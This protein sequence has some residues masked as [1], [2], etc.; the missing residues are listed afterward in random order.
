[1][2]S[3]VAGFPP[4]ASIACWNG[5]ISARADA[6]AVD[7]AVGDGLAGGIHSDR[8]ERIERPEREGRGN[9]K[10][11]RGH[12]ERGEGQLAVPICLGFPSVPSA[13][14]LRQREPPRTGLTKPDRFQFGQ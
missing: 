7:P 13:G 5:A 14:S 1:M 4:T 8:L 11:R 3:V 9:Q 12:D 6:P 10:R 2:A